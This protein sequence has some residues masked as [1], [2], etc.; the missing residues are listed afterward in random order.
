MKTEMTAVLTVV[1]VLAAPAYADEMESVDC[2]YESNRTHA[3]CAIEASPSAPARADVSPPPLV[4][5]AQ[6]TR[7]EESVDC[8]YDINKSNPACR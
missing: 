5:Y 1:A 2:F 4:A 8:F 6:V 7:A 3:A